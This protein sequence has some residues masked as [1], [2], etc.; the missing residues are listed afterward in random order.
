[1]CSFNTISLSDIAIEHVDFFPD[2]LQGQVR[3]HH[4]NNINRLE[5]IKR[6]NGRAATTALAINHLFSINNQLVYVHSKA[7]ICY[8]VD[9]DNWESILKEFD[10]LMNKAVRES[11]LLVSLKYATSRY[12]DVDYTSIS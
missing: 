5:T 6:E 7:Q 1:M 8:E 12:L 9:N 3:R 4:P 10:T 2:T 11:W